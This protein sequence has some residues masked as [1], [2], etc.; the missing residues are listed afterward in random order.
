MHSIKECPSGRVGA[1]VVAAGKG[2]RFGGID[3]V[4]A[5]LRGLPLLLHTLR[6]F[7]DCSQ[8]DEVVLVLSEDNIQDAV[9]LLEAHPIPKVREVCVGGVRRQ[10]SVLAGLAK[11]SQNCDWVLVHDGA[12]PCVDT[13]LIARG[14]EAARE[15]GAAAAAVPVKDTIKLVGED[16]RIMGTPARDSLWAAQTPQVFKTELLR[17]AH[18]EVDEDVTDD[19]ALVERLGFP[20]MAFM[21]SYANLKVTTPEDLSLAEYLLRQHDLGKV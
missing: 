5:S 14:I 1:V 18:V 20:V 9:S 2:R 13:T 19:A 7:E 3:K 4:F 8:I 10:D 11:L 6:P 12:R 17:R 16:G 15:T 21:G